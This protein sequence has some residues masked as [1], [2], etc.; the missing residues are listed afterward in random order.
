MMSYRKR[1]E[2]VCNCLTAWGQA[3]RCVLE[4]GM[5]GDGFAEHVQRQSQTL[6]MGER[7]EGEYGV[8]SIG[9]AVSALRAVWERRA[10]FNGEKLPGEDV[11]VFYLDEV[12]VLSECMVGET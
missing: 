2:C 8:L 7:D 9:F 6:T 11:G 4:Y 10:L 1:E 5:L 12:K 3:V